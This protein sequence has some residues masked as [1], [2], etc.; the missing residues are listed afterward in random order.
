[1]G[2]RTRALLDIVVFLF[3]AALFLTREGPDYT[4][5]SVLGLVALAA[6]AAHLWPNRRWIKSA[7]SPAGWRRKVKLS[8][9]N[10]VLAVST[11]VCTLT[12]VASWVG[13]S[14]ADG[15]HAIT[16]FISLGAAIVHGIR[17]R[18]L[19]MTMARPRT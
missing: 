13:V 10:M 11:A 17:N 19:F 3:F 16:G 2:F 1:M 5:H 14:A 4:V 7:W 18:R 12:G 15:P 6:I 8:R 9:L